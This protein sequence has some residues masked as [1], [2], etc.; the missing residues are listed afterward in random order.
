MHFFLPTIVNSC[1]SSAICY[2]TL[3]N[4]SY[5]YFDWAIPKKKS[6]QGE[7]GDILSWN[8]FLASY[9]YPWKFQTKQSFTP[10]NS[11]KL[12][13]TPASTWFGN[14]NTK[15]N[16]NQHPMKFHMIFSLNRNSTFLTAPG[17]YLASYT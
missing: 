14:S 7:F 15:R 16:W 3:L 11:T 9:S 1:V 13:F 4:S 6:I 10:G 5:Y 12:C 2:V 8:F 17:T